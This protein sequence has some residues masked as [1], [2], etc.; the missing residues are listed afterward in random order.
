M[1]IRRCV[2]GNF[3][4]DEI[5]KL[6]P[7]EV[8]PELQRLLTLLLQKFQREW[9]EDAHKDQV[10]PA[11]TTLSGLQIRHLPLPALPRREQPV[12]FFSCFPIF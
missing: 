2:Y 12:F 6:F 5:Q 10:R 3:R 4:R 1:L 7:E 8:T 9:R 11:A